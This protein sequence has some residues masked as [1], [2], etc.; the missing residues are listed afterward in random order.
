[1]SEL[2]VICVGSATY[3][4]IAS[5]ARMP[6]ADERMLADSFMGAGG[7][8]AATAAVALA[9]LGA[10]VGFCG[11]AGD[12]EAGERVRESL[13]REGVDVRW[14]RV[15]PTAQTAQSSIIVSGES[16]AI[17]AWPATEPS[18]GDVPLGASRWLHADQSGFA[19]VQKALR[20]TTDARPRLSVDAGN[21][22]PSGDLAGVD[23]FVPSVSSLLSRYPGSA[24]RETAIDAALR[25]G[26]RAVVATDGSGGA[27]LRD[28]GEGETRGV[29]GFA[30]PVVSTLGAGD[31][32]HGAL[33][34]ALVAGDEL[35]DAVRSANAVAALSCRALD[36]R[37]AIPGRDELAAFL[38]SHG[39]AAAATTVTT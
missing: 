28:A 35:P 21:P 27:Y 30:V 29:A 39:E 38:N 6:G 17:V 1:M 33:L 26:A 32:F 16:R 10:S 9:R 31:V 7:G 2:D 8:P 37:S 15:L 18:V 3:D 4:I 13:E 23:L 36:G 20:A 24:D 19:P 34:A 12:D 5:V 11:V 22:L 14:L 25:D